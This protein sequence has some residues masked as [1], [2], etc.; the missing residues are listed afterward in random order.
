M[1]TYRKL[2]TCKGELSKIHAGQASKTYEKAAFSYISDFPVQEKRKLQKLTQNI[3]FPLYSLFWSVCLSIGTVF[4][5]DF[6]FAAK[7]IPILR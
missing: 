7:N 5:T 3:V 1:K 4:N 2:N 6:E